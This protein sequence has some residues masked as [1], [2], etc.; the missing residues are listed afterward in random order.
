[1]RPSKNEDAE[2]TG[3]SKSIN[4]M[5]ENH[6]G[7]IEHHTKSETSSYIFTLIF[8]IIN[9]KMTVKHVSKMSAKRIRASRPR[10]SPRMGSR[11]HATGSISSDV[12]NPLGQRQRDD[13]AI[14]H[15]SDSEPSSSDSDSAA[16]RSLGEVDTVEDTTDT[17]PEDQPVRLPPYDRPAHQPELLLST[18][19]IIGAVSTA[20]QRA[21]SSNQ[22]ADPVVLRINVMIEIWNNRLCC[23]SCQRTTPGLRSMTREFMEAHVDKAVGEAFQLTDP[24]N[25]FNV[26][27]C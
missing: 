17:A 23:W 18:Q 10:G 19:G 26:Y 24:L 21:V 15:G 5:V 1:M 25:I 27:G 11:N 6:S 3:W 16:S 14:V 22:H 12:S 2:M 20:F 7:T 13:I 8:Q 4:W 9:S